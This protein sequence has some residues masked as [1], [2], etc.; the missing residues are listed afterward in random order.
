MKAA[1]SKGNMMRAQAQKH[2][3]YTDVLNAKRI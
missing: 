3:A 2:S 1:K